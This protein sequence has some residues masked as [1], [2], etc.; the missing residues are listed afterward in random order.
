MVE[1]G[2]ERCYSFSFVGVMRLGLGAVQR[3]WMNAFVPEE[4]AYWQVL[5]SSSQHSCIYRIG[6]V[7]K[8]KNSIQMWGSKS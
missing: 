7:N 3:G 2:Y 8:R 5:V 6:I 1:N 4:A